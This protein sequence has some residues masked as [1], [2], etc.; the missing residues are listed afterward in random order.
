VTLR[1]AVRVNG[2]TEM[3][4]TKLDILSRLDTLELCVA[5]ELDGQR[6][7]AF[8]TDLTV[9]ARCR[10]VY[11]TLPGWGTDITTARASSELP[12]QARDYVTR[13]EELVGIPASCISV[14]PGRDQTIRQ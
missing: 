11:E 5:Y 3:A 8:P 7:E 14:G 2:L 10:P 4:I 12:Q 9:L 13:I 1:Y 6:I